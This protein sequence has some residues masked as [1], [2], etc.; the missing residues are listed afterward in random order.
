VDRVAESL[1]YHTVISIV[2]VTYNSAGVLEPCSRSLAG[3]G[4][5][6]IVVDNASS[7]DSVKV[8]EA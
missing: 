3:S 5:E 4:A 7:D 8:A 1:E 2:L 6:I